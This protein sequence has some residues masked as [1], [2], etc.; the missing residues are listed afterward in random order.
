MHLFI[1]LDE[2]SKLNCLLCHHAETI[3]EESLED[4]A[5]SLLSRGV[6]CLVPSP[7]DIQHISLFCCQLAI[8]KIG[9]SNV[10]CCVIRGY[11]VVI[12]SD[13]SERDTITVLKNSIYNV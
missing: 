5:R 8:Y 4:G 7:P 2:L 13:D 9:H 11:E 3:V 1:K 6:M 10:I 12:R